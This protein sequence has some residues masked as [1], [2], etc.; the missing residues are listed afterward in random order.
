MKTKRI[1]LSQ[2]QVL[3]LIVVVCNLLLI[4]C[5]HGK[6]SDM[7]A[8]MSPLAGVSEVKNQEW[9][10]NAVIYEVNI[11]QYTPEGTF[12]A[13]SEHL[14]RLK[15]MG[16]DILWLM[17][18]HPIGQMNRKGELGSYYSVKDYM[19]INPEFGDLNDF[20]T[21]VKQIHETGMYVIMDWVPNHSSWDNVL[22]LEHPDFYKTTEDGNFASPFDWTDVIQLDYDNKD[23]R[24]YMINAMKYWLTET[25][26]DGFRCDV[27]HMVPVDFWE[28]ARPALEQ[29]KP[30]FML[31]ES[32]Q[33]ELNRK[34]F[35]M[36]YGWPFFHLMNEIAAGNKTANAI[37]SHFAKVD[38]VYPAGS[39]IM[40]FT[41]NHD[42][43]SWSGTEYERMD[44]GAR[45]F[46][47][48]AATIPGMPLI[49]SGQ[50]V[51]LNKR[52]KF[53]E[54]DTIDWKESE[55][56]D[57]YKD[58][59]ALKKRNEALWN[60]KYGGT[61]T[62]ITSTDNKS[63]YAFIREKGNDRV[64]VILNLTGVPVNIT[65]KGSIY[66]GVYTDIFTGEQVKFRKEENLML[67]PWMYRVYELE[68]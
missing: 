60:G 9:V 58:L 47:V 3:F 8:T 36:T 55:M 7:K 40:Q 27:A 37:S 5:D 42:E 11:R 41:S 14:P 61:L 19:R 1:I 23:L 21:L 44:G 64:F 67:T 48:L 6:R 52:L 28:E 54:K 57:F 24:A 22:T 62:R 39:I 53:F 18:I 2:L 32:D 29:V 20:K 59:I 10:K 56:T 65:L 4:S 49:Y 16:V 50:E 34:A 33:P 45:T 38:S 68:K 51:G 31:A 46:A 35:D 15:A 17:P 43:N 13:F 12:K 26:I 30:V 63:V 66:K 25:D